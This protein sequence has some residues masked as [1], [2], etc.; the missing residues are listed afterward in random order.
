M[1]RPALRRDVQTGG[2]AGYGELQ[3]SVSTARW[4]GWAILLTLSTLRQWAPS[5][6]KISC[7]AHLNEEQNWAGMGVEDT[8]PKV[9]TGD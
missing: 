8:K 3:D 7:R 5:T 9:A 6:S 2:P 1:S 4:V